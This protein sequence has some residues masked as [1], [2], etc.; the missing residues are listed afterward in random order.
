MSM[1]AFARCSFAAAAVLCLAMDNSQ[2]AEPSGTSQTRDAKPVNSGAN[3][4]RVIR[5]WAQITSEKRPWG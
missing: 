3:P 1:S 2:A 4:Y 5:D